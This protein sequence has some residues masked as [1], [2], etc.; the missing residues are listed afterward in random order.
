MSIT[1]HLQMPV[2]PKITKSVE[3]CPR[4]TDSCYGSYSLVVNSHLFGPSPVS[5]REN[6]KGMG[7]MI[8]QTVRKYIAIGFNRK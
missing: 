8:T 6:K 3:P 4:L 1:F 7:K 2:S 5:R